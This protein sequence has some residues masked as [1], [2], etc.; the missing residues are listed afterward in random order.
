[1]EDEVSGALGDWGTGTGALGARATLGSPA[2]SKYEAKEQIPSSWI[3]W[4]TMI[5]PVVLKAWS[6]KL[7]K[8]Q[9][10]TT[11]LFSF[12]ENVVKTLLQQ[13]RIGNF[14]EDYIPRPPYQERRSLFS[15]SGNVRKLSYSNAEFYY[16]PQDPSFGKGKWVEWKDFFLLSDNLLKLL[17]QW[18]IHSFFRGYVIPSDPSFRGGCVR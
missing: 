10:I 15:F 5:L 16:V 17:Q 4:L 14:S 1:M 18:K 13:C 11:S 9:P 2:S 8:S 6:T 7:S 12:S 3:S